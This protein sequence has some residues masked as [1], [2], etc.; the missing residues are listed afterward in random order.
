MMT[1]QSWNLWILQKQISRERQIISSWNKKIIS[2]T[3][4]A[5]L[6]QKNSIVA[7]LT[8]KLPKLEI[9]KFNGT[10]LDWTR[11]WSQFSM[12]INSW[13]LASLTKLSYLKEFLETKVRGIIDELPFL[14][15][16]I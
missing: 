2:Y 15:L 8:F 16:R 9:T 14:F 4:K 1:P 12:E 13:R 3:S 6:L 7:E 11:F 5:T 10:H